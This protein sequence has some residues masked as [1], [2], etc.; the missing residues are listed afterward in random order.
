MKSFPMFLTM[1][2]RRVVIVG[3]GETAAQKARLLARTEATLVIAAPE[4]DAE[5]AALVSS[6]R[7]QHIRDKL[8]AEVF[9]GAAM[10]FV[11]T[12]CRALDA[13]A[14]AFAKAAGALVN[15]VDTPDL[16]DATMPSI[17]DRDPVVVAIGTEGNAPVLARAIKTRIETMLDPRIGHYAGLTGRL[18]ALVAARVPQARRRSFWHWIY[19]GTPF[20]EFQRGAERSAM[21]MI[22]TAIS[23]GE[24]GAAGCRLTVIEA[25]KVADLLPMRALARLQEADVLSCPATLPEG[26]LDLARRDAH[27]MVEPDLADLPRIASADPWT[28]LL[29]L[30]G[31]GAQ[32]V[33]ILAAGSLS[34]VDLPALA[35][36]AAAAGVGLELLG[37]GADRT[38]STSP[39]QN[40]AAAV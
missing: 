38:A 27:R 33:R 14:H 15:V 1:T 8:S 29:T 32:V 36:R 34:A 35:D 23:A 25:P 18:R 7:A 2:G 24:A 12:G 22:K 40:F 5:L 37:S 10:V 16:C 21:E 11:G 6:G 4:L 3:G 26:L 39:D 17:V 28:A 9:A 31:S 30:A 19:N 20:Q 13:C